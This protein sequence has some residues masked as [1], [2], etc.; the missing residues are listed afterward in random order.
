MA[1]QQTQVQKMGQLA[2]TQIIDAPA[3]KVLSL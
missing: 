1:Q 2:P 3:P